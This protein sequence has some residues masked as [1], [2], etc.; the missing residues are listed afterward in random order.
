MMKNVTIKLDETLIKHCRIKAV[1]SDKS[2]SQWISDM[3][4]NVI[5]QN[6]KVNKAREHAYITMDKGFSL[7]GTRIKRDQLYDR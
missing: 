1:E 7:G 2:L 3:L 4:K 6:E 5:S